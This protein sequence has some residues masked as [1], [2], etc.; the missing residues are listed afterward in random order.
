MNSYYENHKDVIKK[1]SMLRGQETFYCELCDKKMRN[2][3]KPS[4]LKTDKHKKNEII[5]LSQRLK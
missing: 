4:H 2:S 3:S 1:R 5:Y